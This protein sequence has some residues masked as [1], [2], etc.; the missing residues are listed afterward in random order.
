MDNIEQFDIDKREEKSKKLPIIFY[1]KIIFDEKESLE[2]K[3]L[4]FKN[5]PFIDIDTGENDI[6]TFP[7]KEEFKKDTKTNGIFLKIL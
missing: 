4:I 5:K 7:V 2:Q 3:K 1:H 6:K